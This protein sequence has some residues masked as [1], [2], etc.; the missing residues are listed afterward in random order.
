MSC[1]VCLFPLI[2]EQ[3]SL[4]FM[5]LQYSP[6]KWGHPW[7]DLNFYPESLPC[8]SESVSLTVFKGRFCAVL[9]V[10]SLY[11]VDKQQRC[12]SI[13]LK[14]YGLVTGGVDYNCLSANFRRLLCWHQGA[15][16]TR[17]INHIDLGL[18]APGQS[19]VFLCSS[20]SAL[21]SVRTS[22]FKLTHSA[23]TL[24]V[25]RQGAHKHE[26]KDV[27]DH[28]QYIFKKRKGLGLY[29]QTVYCIFLNITCRWNPV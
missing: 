26:H 2:C 18:S 7:L 24:I 16:I 28:L 14:S 5:S 10:Y 8:L 9:T 29:A 27:N 6:S 15:A 4:C 25:S 21:V 22:F 12:G 11:T 23:S 1:T 17:L 19:S 13:S 20:S 3:R